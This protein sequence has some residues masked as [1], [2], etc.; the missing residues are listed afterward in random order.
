MLLLD[1]PIKSDVPLVAP[2]DTCCNCGSTVGVTAVPTDLRRMPLMGLVGVEIKV[3]LPFP[4]CEGCTATARRRRPGA[5]GLLAATALVA[6]LLGLAWLFLGP[7]GSERAT[8]HVVAPA[9]VS[10]SVAVVGGFFALRRP[11]GT[12]TSY[13]QPVKLAHTGHKWP[14][15][16]TGLELAFTNR[17]FA[18]RF[19]RANQAAVA[20][21]ALKVT[22]A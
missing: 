3:T 16:L 9:L 12:Q 8:L 15:D 21:K 13:Y 22:A 10:L 7:Q 14:A 11:A 17:Q 20:A 1:L 2:A 4:Y 6:L 5:L 19:A 18:E